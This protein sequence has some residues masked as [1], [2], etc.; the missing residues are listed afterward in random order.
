MYFE[1]YKK[2]AH[3][4]VHYS[5]KI[6]SGEKCLIEAK[7]VPDEFLICLIK[8]V[9]SIGAY[10]IV[11]QI[12]TRVNREI[13]QGMTKEYAELKKQYDLPIMQ[14]MDAYIGVRGANN[15]F[16][17]SDVPEERIKI[18]SKFYSEDVH[19]KERVGNTKWCI[20]NFPSP[21]LAQSA[22]MS[23][24]KF[25]EYF[26]NVCNLDYSK[27]DKEMDN[28]KTLMEK[29]DK[30]RIVA[31]NT[32]ITFSIKGMPAIKCAGQMNIPDGE[33]FTAPIKDSIN[34]HIEYNVD[35]IYNGY[36]FSNVSLEIK[37]G[38]IISATAN[39]TEFLNKILD[40]DDGSRFFGEFAIGVNPY[41]IE[42]MLDILFDEKMCGSIHLTP[43]SCYEEANNGNQ[44][45]IHWDMVQ[46][47]LPCYGGGDIYFDDVLIRHNG[48][49]V[50]DELK[51][52]NPENLK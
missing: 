3:N 33:I 2:L 9:Y 49:F 15:K 14:D 26:F 52:L 10:P 42:P 45:A 11:S 34:G 44:S 40:T 47:H 23:T 25:T 21:S 16:E 48:I 43:G 20:L 27:M 36:H 32:D 6:K 38:K 17:L 50:I 12:S 1:E 51:G 18:Y 35:T 24:E 13:M 22:S 37:N 41:I 30:V 28:L 19:H 29:T 4:L 39:N 5:C 7:D 8:E 46:S 31:K